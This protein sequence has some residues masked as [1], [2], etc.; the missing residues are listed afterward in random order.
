MLPYR[1]IPLALLL[2]AFAAQAE[3][4]N[5]DPDAVAQEAFDVSAKFCAARGL[6]NATAR[7]DA[8]AKIA[9]TLVRVSRVW[10][11][12]HVPFLLYWRGVLG[13]CVSEPTARQDL[14]GFV[15]LTERDPANKALRGDAER[16][17]RRMASEQSGLKGPAPASILI[18]VLGGSAAAAGTVLAAQAQQEGTAL[19]ASMGTL[20]GWTSSHAAYEAAQTRQRVGFAI[21]SAGGG[22]A[23]FGAI[24]I[25]LGGT[26]R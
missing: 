22:V 17:L 2:C 26:G 21:L 7:L 1:Y 24:T 6:R 15:R 14:E 8:R 4:L 10:D 12:H 3:D 18:A 16:R 11:E 9:P 23:I 13:L 20:E 25:P 19:G 5:S